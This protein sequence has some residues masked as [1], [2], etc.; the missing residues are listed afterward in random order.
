[1]R[2]RLWHAAQWLAGLAIVVFVARYVARNWAEVRQADLRWEL[3]WSWLLA[4]VVLVWL[5]FALL[6]DGWRRM[7]TGWGYP[8]RWQNGAR[9]WLLSSM[10][11]YVPG[12]VWALAGMAVMSSRQ[13]IPAW[14]ATSSAVVLQLLSLGS[15]AVIVAMTGLTVGGIVPGPL[16][17]ALFAGAMAGLCLVVLW[18]PLLRR[19]VARVTSGA[20]LTHVPG[21]RPLVYGAVVN[22]SAWVG[23]GAAFWLFARATLPLAPLGFHE[24]VGAYTASYIA[25]VV[26]PFA[27]G[28]IG[29]RE[30]VLIMLLEP[31]L[32][33]ANALALAAVSRL[34][35]TAAELTAVLPFL[36][37]VPEATGVESIHS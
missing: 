9:I 10:A 33:L 28:G 32:G 31:R 4:A 13:G 34:G 2:S 14:A 37:R 12:K 20:D 27:P 6:A 7:V 3:S 24:A 23:Y 22:L 19:V 30:G 8:V 26:A 15:A 35:M 16:G 11:K 25:G 17:L 21:L 18:P 1:L 5:V 36:F 29:V